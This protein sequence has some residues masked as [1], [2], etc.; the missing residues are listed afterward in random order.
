MNPRHLLTTL[1]VVLVAVLLIGQVRQLL[2]DPTVWPP[3]DFVEYW[4]AAR[5]ALDGQNTYDGDLL[6]PLEQAA[7]RDT[8]LPIMMWN[9]PWAIPVILP[10]GLFPAREAQ[11]LW[12]LVNLA[13][14]MFCGDRLWLIFGGDRK[15]RWIGWGVALG[16]LPTLFALHSGQ[17]GPLLLLGV[18]LFLEC[19]R[20]GWPILAG[21]ATLLIAIKPHLAYLLWV[22]ILCDALAWRRFGMIIGGVLAGL[23]ATLVPLT[24]N[25]D[26]LLQYADTLGNRPPSQ[27]VTPTIGTV[28]RLLFGPEQFR[29]QVIPVVAGLLWFGR[30][31]R[32]TEWCWEWTPQLPL[33]VL[34][35]FVTAPYGAWPFDMVLLL[36]AIIRL[37]VEAVEGRQLATYE[38]PDLEASPLPETRTRRWVILAALLAV[39]MACL[40]MNL[41]QTGS[42]AFIWVSPVVLLIYA[43]G[44][45][46]RPETAPTSYLPVR[47]TVLT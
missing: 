41:F 40:L 2:A 15:R 8:D 39:N 24:L 19:T 32:K 28:L 34:I 7:G 38:Y 1:G 23:V 17:I 18:V 36:P 6:L 5:L 11:L 47:P 44:T 33:L 14:V 45:R 46:R 35:S 12:L 29:L 16:F 25:P 26:L 43:I 13:A 9:P 42:F 4:A 30:Y 10:L 27:W 37:V 31:W 3:D 21:A 20:R 22:A